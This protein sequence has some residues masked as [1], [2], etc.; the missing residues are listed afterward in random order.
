[1]TVIGDQDGIHAS[2]ERLRALDPDGTKPN[3]DPN[4]LATWGAYDKLERT[5]QILKNTHDGIAPPEP[6]VPP[7]E[8]LEP[9]AFECGVF[10]AGGAGSNMGD[11]DS[12]Q[13]DGGRD[14]NGRPWNP[15]QACDAIARSGYRSVLVQLYREQGADYMACGRARGLRV[16]LWDAWPSAARAELALSY[17]PD[18]YVAQA[19]TGQGQAAMDAIGRAYEINPVLPLGIVTNL[20]PSRD[21]QPPGFDIYMQ[22]RDVIAMPEVYANE[23]PDWNQDP[24]GFKDAL[25]GECLDRGY[26]SVIPVFGVYWGWTVSQYQP[27]GDE[28]FYPYLAEDM[29][30]AELC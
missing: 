23:N 27:A 17:G 10:V 7:D 16:G 13:A 9:T 8:T 24:V 18:M 19:E 22:E 25:V 26:G 6:E 30:H 3:R 28:A 4:N 2:I 11:P 29:S 14:Y 21:N 5:L 1:M 15:D 20:Q 12:P